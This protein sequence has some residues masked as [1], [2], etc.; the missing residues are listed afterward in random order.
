MLDIEGLKFEFFFQKIIY[1]VQIIGKKYWIIMNFLETYFIS[2]SNDHTQ[3][4]R[5]FFQ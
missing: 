3:F 1:N 4:L 5:I 2:L